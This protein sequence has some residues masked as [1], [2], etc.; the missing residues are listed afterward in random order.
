MRACLLL[1]ALIVTSEPPSKVDPSLPFRTDQ[2]NGHL[3]WYRL[4]PGEFPPLG[5]EHVVKGVLLEAD[6]IHRSGQFRRTDDGTLVDFTLPPYGTVFYLNAEADL[7]DVPLGTLL[8]FGTYQDDQGAFTRVATIRD[9][10]TLTADL[11]LDAI[12]VAEGKLNVSGGTPTGRE[13]RVDRHTR[14]W[15]G[16]KAV[17]IGDLTIG[18]RVRIN[19]SGNDL[20]A[21]VWVGVET[22][23][24]TTEAQRRRHTA[25]VKERGLACWIDRVEGKRLTVTLFGD[26]EGLR[27]LLKEERIEP[28]QRWSVGAVVGNDELRTYNPPVDRKQAIVL[29]SQPVATLGHGCGGVRW[30]IEPDL[31]LEGFRK[32]RVIRL[33]AHPS[34]PVND[35]PF[36]ESLYS[37][38]S[39]FRPDPVDPNLYPYRTDS[40]KDH[41]PWYRP[42]PGELPPIDSAHEVIGEL[43]KINENGRS[44]RFRVDRSGEIVDFIMPPY[45]AVMYLDAETDLQDVPLGTRCRFALHQDERGAFTRAA[46]IS[47]EFTSLANRRLT[48]RLDSVRLVEGAILVATQ[49]ALVKD[50][51]E[52]MVRPPDFGRATFAVDDRTR[53]WKGEK[54]GTQGDLSAGDVLLFNTTGRTTLS[55]GTCTDI[56]VGLETHKLAT[57][58]QR[59][60]HIAV[61]K[62]G[63]FPAWIDRMDGKRITITLFSGTRRDFPSLLNGDPNGGTVTARLADDNLRPIDGPPLKLIYLGHPPDS[64]IAGTYGCSGVRWLLEAS[65][66]PQSFRPGQILRVL[67]SD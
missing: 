15:K 36:G 21:E 22:H 17:K 14:F 55:R 1:F 10:F 58:R 13:L 35:M 29:E 54:Q 9:D 56:W 53:V 6:F 51:K 32:G 16:D 61:I 34:W 23:R 49:H 65:E 52:A 28:T 45:G 50:E 31:L 2:S 42:K 18:D 5:S 62:K 11:R 38:V 43:L 33:F 7:R 19:L 37:E 27:G 24:L 39:G 67:K 4:K 48:Y 3:P 64:D 44:G 8:H 12:K 25:F 26:P 59:A 46:V 66:L 30:V 41:L 57:D 40:G 20:C 60:R 47:D 63:G